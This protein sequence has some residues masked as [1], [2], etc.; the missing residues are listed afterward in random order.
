MIGVELSSKLKEYKRDGFEEEPT[1]R[2]EDFEG[3]SKVRW[4]RTMKPQDRD[5]NSASQP[6]RCCLLEKKLSRITSSAYM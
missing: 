1:I 4:L 3:L 2:K 6:L 5:Q